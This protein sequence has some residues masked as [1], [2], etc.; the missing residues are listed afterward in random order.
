MNGKV[1]EVLDPKNKVSIKLSDYN[2]APPMKTINEW[3]IKGYQRFCHDCKKNYDYLNTVHENIKCLEKKEIPEKWAEAQPL[4][5]KDSNILQRSIPATTITRFEPEIKNGLFEDFTFDGQYNFNCHKI[6]DGS[7]RFVSAVRNTLSW[8]WYGTAGEQ[9]EP[10]SDNFYIRKPGYFLNVKNTAL[11]HLPEYSEDSIDFRNI[12]TLHFGMWALVDKSWTSQL[13]DQ[14]KEHNIHSCLEIG[15]G[16]G[17]LCKAL[18]EHGISVTATDKYVTESD[19]VT[20]VSE[21][22]ARKA[23]ERNPKADALIICWP[24]RNAGKMI[25]D[26]PVGKWVIYIGEESDDLPGC[27]AESDFFEQIDF[28][29]YAEIPMPRWRGSFD[30][31]L[32]GKKV[33]DRESSES[34][35]SEYSCE[36]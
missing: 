34:S 33:K 9:R 4:S 17:Y 8:L 19:T 14:I 20:T 30:V 3:N 10:C 29:P 27:N 32:I 18:N 35:E 15:A 6:D 1:V 25:A 12:I 2:N 23:I 5:L 7:Y 24:R 22:D 13:A 28:E 31:C 26:W 16:N 11:G 36:Y 21:Q